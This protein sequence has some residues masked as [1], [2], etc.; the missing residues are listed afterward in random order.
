MSKD[1]DELESRVFVPGEERYKCKMG[2]VRE[3]SVTLECKLKLSG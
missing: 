3:I 1:T 2:E